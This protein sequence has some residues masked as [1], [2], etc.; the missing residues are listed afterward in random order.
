MET[1][2][3]SLRANVPESASSPGWLVAQT[4]RA[5]SLTAAKAFLDPCAIEFDD[6]GVGD[7]QRFA[8]IGVVDDRMLLVASTMRGDV[9]RIISARGAEPHEKVPRNLSWIRRSRR[10]PVGTPSTR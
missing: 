4:Q 5:S 9:V 10:S 2:I 1:A 7:E 6:F 8:V 3:F